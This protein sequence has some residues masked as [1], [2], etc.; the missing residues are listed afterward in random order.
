MSNYKP[1]G[2]MPL[3]FC[4]R[5]VFKHTSSIPTEWNKQYTLH[6]ASEVGFV[7]SDFLPPIPIPTPTLQTT[8]LPTCELLP[9]MLIMCF[10][11]LCTL[12]WSPPSFPKFKS[13]YLCKVYYNT[14]SNLDVHWR[15]IIDGFVFLHRRKNI[16]FGFLLD[17]LLL[18]SV[19]F[20]NPCMIKNLRWGLLVHTSALHC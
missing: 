15:E 17:S 14:Q 12:Y 20:L 6:I 13:W 4:Q 2:V 16:I 19:K 3:D 8:P 5:P 18:V 1:R 11:E 7:C 10:C 9:Y